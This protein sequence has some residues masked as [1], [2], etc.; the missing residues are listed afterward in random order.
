[1]V[2]EFVP[3]LLVLLRFFNI[4]P[5]LVV[6]G[7]PFPCEFAGI[8]IELISVVFMLFRLGKNLF[9]FLNQFIQHALPPSTTAGRVSPLGTVC[10]IWIQSTAHTFC[11]SA[12]MPGMVKE[13]SLQ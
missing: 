5:G 11:S 4:F 13:V 10:R 9:T 8:R 6:Q 7:V 1:L 2:V 3:Q 12:L